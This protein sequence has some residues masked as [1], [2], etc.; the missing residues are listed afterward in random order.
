MKRF[1]KWIFHL[2]C[3]Q[4]LIS[5][6]FT[7]ASFL[8]PGKRLQETTHWLAI[9]HPEP[10]YPV[11]ILLI[12]KLPCR[13]WIEFPADRP[14]VLSE[15]VKCTQGIIRERNLDESGYRLIVNGGIYQTFPHL[16]FHLVSGSSNLEIRSNDQS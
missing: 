11:H 6:I 9:P 5:W 12:P 2:K 8:I 7:H 1:L 4:P 10:L 3:V 15:F 14:D 13:N 16:H